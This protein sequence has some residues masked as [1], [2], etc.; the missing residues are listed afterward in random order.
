MPSLLVYVFE[1]TMNFNVNTFNIIFL[2]TVLVSI[3][4]VHHLNA[5]FNN[6]TL[7]TAKQFCGNLF[8]RI[9]VNTIISVSE[10]A[11]SLNSLHTFPT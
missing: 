4:N 1:I 5:I 8:N 2:L 7:T 3:L 6:R 11:D 10:P 9:R